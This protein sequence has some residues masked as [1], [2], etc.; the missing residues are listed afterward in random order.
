[1]FK[2]KICGK[3]TQPGE[4]QY[5]KIVKTRNKTYHNLDK[6]GKERISKGSEIVKE[7]NVCEKCAKE[8]YW[9]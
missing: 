6:Y 8:E 5:K 7:I 2:C 4:K 3:M 9:R 1:M